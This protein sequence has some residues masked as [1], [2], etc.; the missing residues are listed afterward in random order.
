LAAVAG[1]RPNVLWRPFH[2]SLY[3]RLG[4]AAN[5]ESVR[6][7]LKTSRALQRAVKKRDI[8]SVLEMAQRRIEAS[9]DAAVRAIP[10][11][12]K[13]ARKSKRQS[14]GDVKAAV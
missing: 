13:P 6:N 8:E 14:T 2:R 9:R 12:S 4:L 10:V 7:A 5:P 1:A 11:S 3:V